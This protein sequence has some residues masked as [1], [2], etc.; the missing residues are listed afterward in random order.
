M[1]L[2][3]QIF[4]KYLSLPLGSILLLLSSQPTLSVEA[5][6]TLPSEQFPSSYETTLS[7]PTF[8]MPETQQETEANGAFP[9]INNDPSIGFPKTSKTPL[10]TPND[11][12][13]QTE[14]YETEYS[15]KT[16]GTYLNSQFDDPPSFQNT[17][18]FEQNEILAA[19]HAFFGTITSGLANGIEYLFQNQGKPNAYILGEDAGGAFLLG[20]RYGEGSIHT[21]ISPPEKVFWQGPTIGYDAGAEGSKTM[22]LVYNLEDTSQIY[23]RYAGVQGAVYFIGG[24]SIQLQKHGNVTLALIRSGVGLRLGANVGYLNYT[25]TPSWNPL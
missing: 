11:G 23:D 15:V 5:I 10:W 1:I 2:N 14:H 17:N 24:L 25:R 7:K 20:L 21:K 18:S 9:S 6:S 16:A 13:S 19:G 22:I 12:L 8:S 4:Y 3:S